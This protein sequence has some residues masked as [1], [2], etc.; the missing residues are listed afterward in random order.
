MSSNAPAVEMNQQ[1]IIL[2]TVIKYP[3]LPTFVFFLLMMAVFI[4]LSPTTRDGTNIF[5]SP[6]NLSNIIEATATFSIGAFAMTL[7]LLVGQLDLSGESVIALSAVTFGLLLE[8]GVPFPLAILLTLGVGFVCGVINS[9]LVLNFRV[10]S[11]LATIAVA[12]VYSGLAF[13]ISSAR[14]IPVT[15]PTLVRM[16]GSLGS[17]ASFLG[18]PVLLVWTLLFLIGM[19][20]LISRSKFGRW[21]Q[22]TGGNPQAAHSSGVN[23]KAVCATAFIIMGLVGSFIAI[24]LT[25]RLSVASPNFGTGYPLSLIMAAVLGGTTFTGEGGNVF[26]VLL[27]SLVIGVLSNGLGIIG[28]GFHPQQVITGCVIVAAVVFSIYISNRK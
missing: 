5:L 2:R 8:Q 27:G 26:G 16:F 10:P 14:T 6:L 9:V 21:A 13:M 7:V 18:L 17:G 4:V 20:L 28:V 22:A 24:I 15:E 3:V 12:L 19:Y 11:F 23:T 25:A 1:S